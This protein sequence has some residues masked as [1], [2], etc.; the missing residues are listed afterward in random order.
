MY[1]VSPVNA[2]IPVMEVVACI[3]VVTSVVY[4]FSTEKTAYSVGE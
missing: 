1:P 4:N 3:G 2:P